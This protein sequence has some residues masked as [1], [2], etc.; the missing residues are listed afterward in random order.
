MARL[1]LEASNAAVVSSASIKVGHV[2]FSTGAVGDLVERIDY[3][4]DRILDSHLLP[5]PIP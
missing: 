2:T 3:P 5:M 1:D 4:D